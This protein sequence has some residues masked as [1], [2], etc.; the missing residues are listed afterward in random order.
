MFRSVRH[1]RREFVWWSII[2]DNQMFEERCLISSMS[3]FSLFVEE[4]GW[5][6]QMRF[7]V[8]WNFHNLKSYSLPFILLALCFDFSLKFICLFLDYWRGEEARAFNTPPDQRVQRSA[9][10]RNKKSHGRARNNTAGGGSS[11][12]RRRN[13]KA[14]RRQRQ[15]WWK[16]TWVGRT[17][18]WIERETRGVGSRKEKAGGKGK[19]VTN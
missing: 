13:Q 6:K 2:S 4:N 19:T 14:T 7:K 16:E 1:G 15:K 18:R 12:K 9:W 10:Q 17:P 3:F 11:S 8:S 5:I